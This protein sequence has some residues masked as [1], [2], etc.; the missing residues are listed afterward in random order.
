MMDDPNITMEQYIK[1]QAE[2]A[3]RLGRMFNWE[4]ATY[5]K[6]YCNDLDIFIDFEADYLAIVYNDALTSNENFPSKPPVK[7]RSFLGL[8]GY[9]RRFIENFSKIAKPLTQLTQK[10]KAYVWRDKQEEAF[11]ILKEKLSRQGDCICLE[12]IKNTLEELYHPRLGIGRGGVCLKNLE[13]ELNMR[14]R[15]WVEL[16]SD[17]ECEIKYHP[18]KANVVADALSRKERLKPRRVR[19]MSMTI[20]SGLKAKILEA[21]GEASKDLKAPAEWLWGLERHFEKRDDD[22]VYFFDRVW[23]PLVGGI[24]KLIL[25]EAHTSRYSVHPDADKMYYDLRD[26]YWCP[27][28]KRDIAEYVSKCLTCSKIKAEH[29]KPSGL[30][31]QPKIPEWIWEKIT[32]DLVTKLP[33]IS[34]RHDAIWV[35]VDRLTK[36]T[37]FLPIREDYKTEKLARIY[38]NEIVARHGVPISIISDRDGRFASHLWQALQK[39]LGTKRNMS[40]THHPETDVGI[41][42]SHWLNFRIITAT[43]R[44]L[45]VHLSR[46]CTD[47]LYGRKCRS[48]VIWTK[49]RESQLIGPEIVQ[50]TT[51]KIFQIKERLKTAKS[52]KKSYADKRDQ[53]HQYLRFKGLE[54]I[55]ADIA[56]FEERLGKIYGR[57]VHQGVTVRDVWGKAPYELD[58]VY[59]RDGST[60]GRGDEVRWIWC[61]LGRECKADPR[62]GGSDIAERSQ[63]PVMVTMTDLSYL[64][65]INDVLDETWAWVTLGPYK[66]LD[67][68]TGAPKVAKG[69]PDVDE[70]AHAIL[71]PLEAPQPPPVAAQDPCVRCTGRRIDDVITSAPQQPDP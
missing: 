4:T 36:S 67:A 43:T 55:D 37:H 2:K 17:Y 6:S 45:N 51:E 62:Q 26:L 40:T 47:A 56:N 20:Q 49:I 59:S 42:T 24:R 52:R 48:S 12:T 15:R 30:L 44:A 33:K 13:K 65:G 69:A 32:M 60:Y 16:L 63:A 38:I 8:A 21:Q 70:G 10:N 27:G 31:Q 9:Y 18:G 35:V 5:G 54:Y 11:C 14:Q 25:D 41:L 23:I 28:M 3:P 29:Q 71:T 66:Q 19:A 61:I 46:R 22:G 57:G 53:R 68:T 7:I 64:M 1:L 39:A 58:R 34:S 50:E